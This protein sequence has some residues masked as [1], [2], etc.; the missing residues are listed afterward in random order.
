[1]ST[2][3]RPGRTT[4]PRLVDGE[5]LDRATFHERYAALPPETRAELIGGVVYMGSPLGYEHGMR[6]GDVVDWLGYYKRFTPGLIRP[7]NATTQFSDY[8]EPQPD[9]QLIIPKELGGQTKFVGGYIVGPPELVVEVAKSTCQTDLG[10]KKKDYQRAGV[11]E[12]IV[13][14]IDPD[15]VRWFIRRKSRFVEMSPG[16]DGIHRSEVF[17]GLSLDAKA[18]LAGDVARII[19]V[20]DQGLAT[21]KHAAFVERLA[22]SRTS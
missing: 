8:G 6:D 3:D 1:M 13:V 9:C 16:P 22:Q 5:R 19:A 2:I 7:L 18:L 21:P 4:L 11:R 17:P 20:L 15:E 10:Q 12:Y 14:G